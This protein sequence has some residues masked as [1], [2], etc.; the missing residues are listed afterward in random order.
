[1]TN[2]TSV[3]RYE[4]ANTFVEKWHNIIHIAFINVTIP[5]ITLPYFIWSYFSYFTTDIGGDAFILPFSAW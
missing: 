2:P 5:C 4:Q 1:M 3:A